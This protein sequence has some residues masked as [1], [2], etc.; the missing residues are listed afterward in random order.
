MLNGI[1]AQTMAVN[2][3]GDF[4]RKVLEWGQSKGVLSHTEAGVLE[5]AAAMPSR[6]PTKARS[7]RAMATLRKLHEEGCQL[8]QDMLA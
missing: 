1:E 8:G 7:A 2:A 3:G 5:I 4:W 6:L